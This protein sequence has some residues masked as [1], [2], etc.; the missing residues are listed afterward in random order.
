MFSWLSIK[1]IYFQFFSK[2]W[3]FTSNMKKKKIN[4]KYYWNDKNNFCFLFQSQL[5]EKNILWK[6]LVDVENLSNMLK[7]LS[8]QL[9]Q[10]ICQ[11]IIKFSWFVMISILNF[12]E[13]FKNHLTKILIWIFFSIC[14][15]KKFNEI[16]IYDNAML[17][18]IFIRFQIVIK[19]ININVLIIIVLI[20]KIN[21]KIITFETKI[22][23]RFMIFSINFSKIDFLSRIDFDIIITSKILKINKIN[24][25]KIVFMN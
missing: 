3:N 23:K 16:S 15:K 17:I 24:K 10:R 4:S 19:F 14:W 22:S 21:I 9:S 11:F 8:K 13:I 12:N 18:T 6:M 7:F 5:F 25:I 20:I 2:K 1:I